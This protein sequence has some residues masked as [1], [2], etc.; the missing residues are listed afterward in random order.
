M[1]ITLNKALV[2]EVMSTE[3][4]KKDDKGVWQKTGRVFK[5]LIFYPFGQTSYPSVIQ[6]GFDDVREAEINGLV[7]K[8]CSVTVDQ[9]VTAKGTFYDFCTASPLRSQPSPA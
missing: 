4:Q 1:E 6:A 5:K 8:V 9:K 7:G 3:E 2:L